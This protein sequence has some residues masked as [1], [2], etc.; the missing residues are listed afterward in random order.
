MGTAL[1]ARGL[2]VAA[3]LATRWALSDLAAVGAVH[4]AHVRAGAGVLLT[5]TFGPRAPSRP[6]RDAAIALARSA[7]ADEG[8]EGY[9]ALSLWADLPP[10]EVREAL[11][12][13]PAGAVDA[14]WLETGTTGPTAVESLRAARESSLPVVVTL[15]FTLLGRDLLRWLQTLSREGAAA[16]GL[17]CAPWPQGPGALA[18]LAR[19]LAGALPSPLAMKPDGGGLEADAWAK[20]VWAAAEAGARLVGGCC[21]TTPLHLAALRA[22]EHVGGRGLR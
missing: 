1:I 22:A 16:V 11:A 8:R 5:D 17:N 2:D 7:F 12:G 4:R 3:D 15:A 20:E 10:R 9:V 14:V 21:G 6:E 18:C 13:L 19:E